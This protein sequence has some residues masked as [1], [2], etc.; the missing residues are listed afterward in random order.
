MRVFQF[1]DTMYLEFILLALV[2][3]LPILLSQYFVVD[4]SRYDAFELSIRLLFS[5]F[6]ASNS[7]SSR[8][9]IME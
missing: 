4:E 8:W 6:P 2:A 1:V 7:N 9:R 3:H 5:F